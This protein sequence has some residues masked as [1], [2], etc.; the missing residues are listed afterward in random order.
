MITNFPNGVSSF[1]VPVLGGSILTTGNVFFVDSGASN[2]ADT[3]ANGDKDMPFSSMDYATGRCTPNNGD[4]VIAMPGHA[5]AITA[6]GDL[7]CDV[8]GVTYLGLGRGTDQ[9]TITS[10]S[11]TGDVD[12]DAANVTIEGFH[13]V[14][15]VADNAVGIDV[16]ATDFT[17]RNCRMTGTS[18]LNCKIWI[19]DAAAAASDRMTIENNYCVDA[20]AANTHFVNLAGTGAQHIIRGNILIGDWGTMAIGGAGVVVHPTIDSNLISNAATDN[21]SCINIEATVTG[22]CSRNLVGNGAAQANQITGAALVM[23]Q[24]YGAV[25]TEDLSGLIEPAAT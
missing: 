13:F 18:G 22:L 21:D 16:N 24:N 2:A 19:Q 14:A 9:P 25:T 8:A 23:N 20:D 7:N 4:F 17:I 3:T 15:A 5:E 1:G 11:A 10:T 6:A 12:I